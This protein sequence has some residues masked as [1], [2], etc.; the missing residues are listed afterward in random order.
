MP[1][2]R[3]PRKSKGLSTVR[4]ILLLGIVLALVLLVALF[5]SQY[6][7]ASTNQYQAVARRSLQKLCQNYDCPESKVPGQSYA[8]SALQRIVFC[9]RTEYDDANIRDG[10]S[11]DQ[12]GKQSLAFT[13]KSEPRKIY[14]NVE[15]VKDLAREG[16]PLDDALEE[17][18]DHEVVHQAAVSQTLPKPLTLTFSN[19]NFVAVSTS[20]LSLM[21]AE[22][23]LENNRSNEA[24]TQWLALPQMRTHEVR[25]NVQLYDAGPQIVDALNVQIGLGRKTAFRLYVNE[26]LPGFSPYFAKVA[27]QVLTQKYGAYTG[28]AVFVF[29]DRVLGE[30][31]Q[32]QYSVSEA[33]RRLDVFIST[34]DTPPQK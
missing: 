26:G 31:N 20:G 25:Y 13:T 16:I 27:G 33:V 12:S 9:N 14:V 28:F 4:F 3:S 30:I 19:K 18:L 8:E 24:Y 15:N 5:V 34:G 32:N 21:N 23:S 6:S 10:A 2:R 29:L 17:I 7:S 11:N 22:G 1:R